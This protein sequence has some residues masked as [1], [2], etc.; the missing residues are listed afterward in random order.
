MDKNNT[1]GKGGDKKDSDDKDVDEK[2]IKW[3]AI[4]KDMA[5]DAQ[6]LIK[7]LSDSISYIAIA[8]LIVLLLGGSALSIAIIQA[9]GAKYIAA[10]VI[11]F[12]ICAFNASIVLRKWYQLRIRYKHLLSLQKEI[13]SK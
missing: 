6:T 13:W 7:D 12:S 3:D 1:D 9:K 4:F 11:I 2:L 10:G 5:T 8:A